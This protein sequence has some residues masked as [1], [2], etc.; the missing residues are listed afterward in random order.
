MAD[1]SQDEEAMGGVAV[2]GC[3]T[4][5][6]FCILFSLSFFFLLLPHLFFISSFH[7]HLS[8]FFF[9]PFSLPVPH[10]PVCPEVKT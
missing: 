8:P 10:P 9:L 4:Q 7:Q 5:F 6:S 1:G 2:S 3:P